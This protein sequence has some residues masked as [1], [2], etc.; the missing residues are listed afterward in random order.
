MALRELGPSL[1]AILFIG[2]N[3]RAKDGVLAIFE[4]V[5]DLL[6]TNSEIPTY[7]SR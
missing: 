6:E 5:D 3:P 1:A 7:G 2:D 4:Q